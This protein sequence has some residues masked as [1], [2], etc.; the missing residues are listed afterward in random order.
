M[1]EGLGLDVIELERIL[2]AHRRFGSRFVSRYLGERERL[3]FARRSDGIAYLAGRFAAKEAVIKALAGFFDSGVWL[4]DIEIL[5][6]A[7]GQPRVH[8]AEKLQKNLEGRNIHI[9][10]THSR[11]TAAA[12]AIIERTN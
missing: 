6:E 2:K 5:N 7:G 1:I 11:H 10:I 12:M 8:L 4:K 3:D 9:S